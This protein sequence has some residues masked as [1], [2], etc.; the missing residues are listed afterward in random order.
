MDLDQLGRALDAFA[1]INPTHF[2]LHHAQVFLAVATRGKCTYADIETELGLS[3]PSVSR[4]VTALGPVH[5]T[6]RDGYHLLDMEPDP[7]EGRR[8]LVMLSP[9]GKALL[10]QLK[11]L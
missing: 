6:G 11:N 3:N 8:F 10:R 7:R 5:R 4:T 2:P 9:K 1:S